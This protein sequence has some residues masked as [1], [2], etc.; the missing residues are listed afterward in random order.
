MGFTISFK[1]NPG[2]AYFTVAMHERKLIGAKM[3]D[4]E[5]V[6]LDGCMKELLHILSGYQLQFHSPETATDDMPL[7]K[8]DDAATGERLT[9]LQIENPDASLKGIDLSYSFPLI[10]KVLPQS[11][12]F[13]VDSRASLGIPQGP[14]VLFVRDRADTISE[15]KLSAYKESRSSHILLLLAVLRDLAQKGMDMLIR[16]TNYKAAVLR[17]LIDDCPG[18]M[19]LKEQK[20]A[21]KT[22][23]S[24]E[25]ENA[26]FVKMQN[27]GYA[28]DVWQQP[29][30][31]R[32]TMANYPT[33]SKEMI[34]LFADRVM[35]L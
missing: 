4:E 11:G 29:D 28:F 31:V 8:L 12:F 17:Q 18:M 25:L 35:A 27:L 3:S 10:P 20:N 16:E 6:Y 30:K 7:Q 2:A 9:D 26:F 13:L 24:F 21:S 22:M 34:E 32:A 15:T 14:Q 5:L 33:H 1:S 23:I 19:A